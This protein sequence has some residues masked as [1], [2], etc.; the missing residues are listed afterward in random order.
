MKLLYLSSVFLYTYV[1]TQANPVNTDHAI[2][3]LK[4]N[5]AILGILCLV[6]LIMAAVIVKLWIKI[7]QMKKERIEDIKERIKSEEQLRIEIQEIYTKLNI[8]K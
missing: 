3:S 1:L 8:S 6:I 7:N 5:N 4:Q 2:N